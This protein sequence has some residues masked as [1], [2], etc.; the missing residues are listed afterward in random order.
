VVVCIGVVVG[1]GV[2]VCIGVVVGTGVVV[3]GTGVVGIGSH[4]ILFN[5]TSSKVTSL[6]NKVFNDALFNL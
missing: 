5:K 2:V 6:P 4:A 3:V 1:T